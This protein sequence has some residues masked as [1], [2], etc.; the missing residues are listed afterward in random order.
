[1]PFVDELLAE[2]DGTARLRAVAVLSRYAG[3]TVYVPADRIVERRQQAAMHMLRSREKT[4]AEVAEILR[5][6]YR[7]SERQSW[8]DIASARKKIV[9]VT[10]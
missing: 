4:P 6:R 10:D 9:A 8:R 3:A 7:I 5:A 1:M 2:L